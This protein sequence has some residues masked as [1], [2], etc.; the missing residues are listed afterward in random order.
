[1][2]LVEVSPDLLDWY[3]GTSHTTVLIDDATTLK[4]RDN[5]PVTP[6]TKRYIRLK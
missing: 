3:S 4:V 1:L 5:T 2:G 6:R